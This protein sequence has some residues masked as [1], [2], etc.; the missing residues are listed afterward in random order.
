[1]WI[2]LPSY[3]VNKCKILSTD[4]QLRKGCY[5]FQ[6]SLEVRTQLMLTY[7]CNLTTAN[8]FTKIAK[9]NEKQIRIKRSHKQIVHGS[10]KIATDNSNKNRNTNVTPT[11]IATLMPTLIATM[12]SESWLVLTTAKSKFKHCS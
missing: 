12:P 11:P 2:V 7:L 10:S 6:W 4:P 5:F 3:K 9:I 8:K 1:M